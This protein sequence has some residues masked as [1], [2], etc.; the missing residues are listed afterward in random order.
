MV[1]G[2]ESPNP[3]KSKMTLVLLAASLM[4]AGFLLKDRWMGRQPQVLFSPVPGRNIVMMGDQI[5]SGLDLEPNQRLSELL[6]KTL[7]KTITNLAA[8]QEGPSPLADQFKR[9]SQINPD[10]A[11][12]SLGAEAIVNKEDLGLT[13][14]K[15]REGVKAIHQQSAIAV[16]LELNPPFMGDNWSMAIGQLC[17]ELKILCIK[18]IYGGFWSHDKL[19]SEKIQPPPEAN[20]KAAQLIATQLKPHLKSP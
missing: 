11:I 4:A 1:T 20:E 18:D 12:L 2:Q 10:V 5:A 6:Q 7:G 15:I 16:Y 9:L 17:N 3:P 19:S 14:T 13:L 8:N